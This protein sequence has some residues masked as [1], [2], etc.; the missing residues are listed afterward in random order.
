MERVT[1]LA[2]GG[3]EDDPWIDD[4]DGILCKA[5]MSGGEGELPLA[6]TENLEDH[7]NKQMVEDYAYWFWNHR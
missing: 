1:I 5:K 6:E 4:T 7:P 2:L 3:F